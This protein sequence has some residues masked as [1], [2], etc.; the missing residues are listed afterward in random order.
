[1]FTPI[2]GERDGNRLVPAGEREWRLKQRKADEEDT[3]AQLA[4]LRRPGVLSHTVWWEEKGGVR[5]TL[6]DY[7]PRSPYLVLGMGA[8]L[9]DAA[10]WLKATPAGNVWVIGHAEVGEGTEAKNQVLSEQRAQVVWAQLARKGV[11]RK[12]LLTAIHGGVMGWGDRLSRGARD[13]P[14]Y[15]PARYRMVEVLL[16]NNRIETLLKKYLYDDLRRKGYEP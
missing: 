2:W 4:K 14:G 11:P 13:D 1:L 6:F 8:V 5:V 16:L 15:D 3:K 9:G 12:Q 10:D 7:L